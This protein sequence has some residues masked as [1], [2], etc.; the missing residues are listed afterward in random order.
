MAATAKVVGRAFMA[1]GRRAERRQEGSCLM[2][3]IVCACI[4][5]KQAAACTPLLAAGGR[6][7]VQRQGASTA[8]PHGIGLTAGRQQLQGCWQYYRY[9]HYN[10]QQRCS[11]RPTRYRTLRACRR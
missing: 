2:R 5:P 7:A 4:L 10:H 8:Q 6:R 11:G 3:A 1:T 9:E